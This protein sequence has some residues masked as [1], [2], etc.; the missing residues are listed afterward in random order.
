MSKL[1]VTAADL[2]CIYTLLWAI[3]LLQIST[4]TCSAHIYY[5]AIQFSLDAGHL[6]C[7]GHVLVYCYKMDETFGVVYNL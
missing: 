6:S 5:I 1:N 4:L 2:K 3:I 7:I